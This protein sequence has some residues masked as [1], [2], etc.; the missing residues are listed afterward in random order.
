MSF[1]KALLNKSPLIWKK[2]DERINIK[3]EEIEF[4]EPEN[5]QEGK[6]SKHLIF[7]LK[8]SDKDIKTISKD[9]TD[10]AELRYLDSTVFVK[11]QEKK[12]K[13]LSETIKPLQEKNQPKITPRSEI[14]TLISSHCTEKVH[15]YLIKNP[16][17][18]LRSDAYYL[19]FAAE[20][21]FI[22]IMEDLINFGMDVNKTDKLFRTPVH[23]ACN[24]G[25][26]EA[27]ILLCGNGA[28]IN[29]RDT[30]G[31]Y[32]I[33]VAF[34]S[35]H[36]HLLE[37]LLLFKADLNSK[38]S[39]GSTILHEL[40]KSSDFE[41]LLYLLETSNVG[42]LLKTNVRDQNGDTPFLKLFTV[43]DIDIEDTLSCIDLLIERKMVQ[44]NSLNQNKQNFLHLSLK[45]SNWEL[46]K[47]VLKIL[48]IKGDDKIHEVIDHKDSSGSTVLHFAI[49][50]F[51]LDAIE[52]FIEFHSHLIN[53]QDENGDTPMHFCLN[54]S[55]FEIFD[56]MEKFGGNLSIKN[57][58]G[59]SVKQLYK[60]K[61]DEHKK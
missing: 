56:S 19:H 4:G 8:I 59:I 33:H 13:T 7:Q 44:L 32:P 26:K 51:C 27:V 2:K 15:E 53:E 35:K 11:P 34:R 52:Y 14:E 46:S 45:H 9:E 50:Y 17:Y 47:F 28:K 40:L 29:E 22:D 18:L 41:G 5:I 57:N 20:F 55:F 25:S 12:R 23:V 43:K 58:K 42:D 6:E 16:K 39:D 1:V 38:K 10:R 3:I 21:N 31:N 37:T 30:Y 24:N 49:Q 61:K 60:N 54:L 48:K 36:Y